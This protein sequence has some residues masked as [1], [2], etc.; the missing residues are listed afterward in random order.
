MIRRNVGRSKGFWWCRSGG[1]G[2][3]EILKSRGDNKFVIQVTT[4]QIFVVTNFI[5]EV[6]SAVFDQLSSNNKIQYALLSMIMSIT[7]MLICIAQLIYKG[8]E[9]KVSWKWKEKVPWFYYP[10]PSYKPFGSLSDIIGLLCSFF[11]CVFATIEYSL[12][13]RHTANPIKISSWPLM[14]SFCLLCSKFQKNS[15]KKTS[16]TKDESCLIS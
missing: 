12:Y 11:E 16:F 1:M 5:L 10:S 13:C 7:T 14:F 2:H 6:P 9:G 8:R 4:E 15:Q 3:R